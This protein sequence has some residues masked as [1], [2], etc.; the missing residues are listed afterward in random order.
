MRVSTVSIPI[1]AVVLAV[2]AIGGPAYIFG[3]PARHTETGPAIFRPLAEALQFVD[4]RGL[5]DYAGL[6]KNRGSL[7]LFAEG[8]ASLSPMDYRDYDMEQR[9]AFWINAYNGFTLLAIVNHYPIQPSFLTSLIYPRNSIRQI[10]G[11]WNKLKF[12]V[13]GSEMT[14]D[15]IEHQILRG[16]FD[17]PRIHLA[18]VCAALSCPP[19]RNQP[20]VGSRLEAQFQDQARRF[21][22]DPSKFR[23]DQDT[24][25]VYLS[26][27][28]KWFGADFVSRYGTMHQFEKFPVEQRAVLNFI[29]SYLS[30]ADAAYLRSGE[31]ELEY[32]DYDWS[33][34]EQ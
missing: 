21:L 33:L 13:M 22:S 32:L 20:Y 34:N 11:V 10:S 19:L 26:E 23:I 17:E 31:Y 4:Q 12:Q 27:I 6:K 1:W 25:T 2:M 18:L 14:L 28:F 8:L 7:D 15:H 30:E 9:I 29:S 16:E 5:V 3:G 24:A